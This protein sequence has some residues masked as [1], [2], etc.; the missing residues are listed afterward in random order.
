[1]KLISLAKIGL[2]TVASISL[3]ACGN[4]SGG[5]TNSTI[6][7]VSREDGSGTHGAFTEITGVGDNEVDNTVK[8][9]II[10]NNTEV[11]ISTVSGN[12][13]AIGYISYGSLN[14]KVKSVSIGGVEPSTKTILDGS[15]ALQRPFNI[16]W[17]S[18]LKKEAQDFIQFIHS[19]EGQK[20]VTDN[21]Y[22]QAKTETNSYSPANLS[23]KISIV[24]STSVTPLME[25][26][27]EAYKE[28]NPNVTI[29]ITSNGSSA[30]MTAAQEGTADIGMLSRELKDD[31]VSTVEHDAIALDGIAV[32]VN[33]E[34][35]L[36][37]LSMDQVNQIFVGKVTEWSALK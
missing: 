2:V 35:K 13:S 21:K 19:Q 33:T 31:E 10:Q 11:V 18:E 17:K 29:D 36:S 25:K 23:G 4:N 3:V 6:E 14:D 28:L 20:I 8:T 32:V 16:V 1:M 37:T 7:V 34:N 26:L 12:P 5:Q 24:G 15:Y 30:G 22:V 9:A 27:A